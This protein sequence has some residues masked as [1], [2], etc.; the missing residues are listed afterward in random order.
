VEPSSVKPVHL[1]NKTLTKQ[2]SCV[3]V[4]QMLRKVYIWNVGEL[5]IVKVFH[6]KK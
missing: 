4:H 6:A 2:A 1:D 3:Y 5:K